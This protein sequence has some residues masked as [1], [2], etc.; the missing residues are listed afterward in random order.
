MEKGRAAQ[1]GPDLLFEMIPATLEFF[2]FGRSTPDELRSVATLKY[3][4]LLPQF[5]NR[6]V[7]FHNCSGCGGGTTFGVI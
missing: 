6:Q 7:N 3:L 1:A 4:T 2:G 5:C